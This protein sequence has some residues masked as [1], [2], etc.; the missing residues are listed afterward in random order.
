MPIVQPPLKYMRATIGTLDVT[1]QPSEYSRE[2]V[3]Q[4]RPRVEYSNFLRPL[5]IGYGTIEIPL[6]WQITTTLPTVQ[7]WELYGIYQESNLRSFAGRR[8]NFTIQLH[9]GWRLY[10]ERSAAPTKPLADIPGV[11]PL[12]S[13]FESIPGGVLYYRRF[14]VCAFMEE[15]NQVGKAKGDSFWDCVVSFFQF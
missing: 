5:K 7:A 9:D 6:L 3:E 14:D 15:P 2:E 1:F 12:Y 4:G 13:G 11:T 10:R 8:S